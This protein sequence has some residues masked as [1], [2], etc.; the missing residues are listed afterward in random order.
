M[1]KKE[2]LLSLT[3][4]AFVLVGLSLIYNI[5]NIEN[6]ILTSN[7]VL[8]VLSLAYYT[9]DELK[10]ILLRNKTIETT[11]VVIV[12]LIYITLL[13]GALTYKL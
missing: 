1:S 5:T 3:T 13:L 11:K 4:T 7:I 9:S 12:V 2:L 8:I 6:G 10:P